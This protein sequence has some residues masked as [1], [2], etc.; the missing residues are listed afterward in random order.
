MAE[1]SSSPTPEE[2]KKL[3]AEAKA[4]EDA[5]QAQLPYKWTQTIQDVDITAP[6]DANLKGR[7]LV[8]TLSKT[9]LKVGVKGRD[10]IIDVCYPLQAHAISIDHLYNRA[11]FPTLSAPMNR[12]GL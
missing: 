3:D 8:V 12:P 9:K 5:E 6:V 11:T 10:A 4:K 1:R 2:R 7:D